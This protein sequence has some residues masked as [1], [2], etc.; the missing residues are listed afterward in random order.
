MNVSQMGAFSATAKHENSGQI[1]LGPIKKI[2]Q[3]EGKKSIS[4][5]LVFLTVF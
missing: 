4:F 3:K 1:G 5:V 2:I